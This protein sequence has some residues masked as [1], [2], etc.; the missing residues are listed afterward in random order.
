MLQYSNIKPKQAAK[1]VHH[2][3]PSIWPKK[4]K[5]TKKK[6]DQQGNLPDDLRQEIEHLKQWLESHSQL[7]TLANLVAVLG[8]DVA[9][10]GMV[11]A[12]KAQQQAETAEDVGAVK[13]RK[14]LKPK[15][16]NQK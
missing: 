11:Q 1:L 14:K 3:N 6:E 5:L 7:R 4:N 13:P 12:V 16:K 9:P 15:I 10:F 2:I 8:D